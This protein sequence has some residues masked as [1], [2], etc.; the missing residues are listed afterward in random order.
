[1]AWRKNFTEIFTY[2]LCPDWLTSDKCIFCPVIPYPIS[3][4]PYVY[5]IKNVFSKKSY[6]EQYQIRSV[7]IMIS[8]NYFASDRL[9]LVCQTYRDK[10]EKHEKICYLCN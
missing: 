10:I 4:G 3:Y 5:Y 7:L 1:M 9:Q 2:R 6:L 8:C